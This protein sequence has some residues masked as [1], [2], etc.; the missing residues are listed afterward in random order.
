MQCLYW[1]L[2]TVATVGYGNFGAMTIPELLL[3]IVWM[4]FGVAFYSIIIGNLSLIIA[5]DSQAS[6]SLLDKLQ[7]I[8][9]FAEKTKMPEDLTHKLKA[10]LDKNFDD[11]YSHIDDQILI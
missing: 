10:F 4:V 5:N 2:Q 1:S 9:E 8:D 3:S 11:L 7:S 6:Q